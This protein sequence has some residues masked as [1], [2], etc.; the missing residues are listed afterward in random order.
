MESKT[1]RVSGN[2]LKKLSN[3]RASLVKHQSTRV[4]WNQVIMVLF[5]EIAAL[6]K[7][8]KTM[9]PSLVAPAP[10]MTYSTT[11]V[12]TQTMSVPVMQPTPVAK[13]IRTIML[14][15][16]GQDYL[17]PST[18]LAFSKLHRPQ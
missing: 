11:T 12:Q 1:I 3:M 6:R 5:D 2:P 17:K 4:T 18:V 16:P 10:V 8:L 15:T 7:E 9:T 14:S 13:E